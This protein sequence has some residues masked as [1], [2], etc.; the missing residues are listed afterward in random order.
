MCWGGTGLGSSKVFRTLSSCWFL[1]ISL[2]NA[3]LCHLFTAVPWTIRFPTDRRLLRCS[4]GNLAYH[5]DSPCPFKKN[6]SC[7]HV[8]KT[9]VLLDNTNRLQ[10]EWHIRRWHRLRFQ[11]LPKARLSTLFNP[12]PS[13]C[14]FLSTPLAEPAFISRHFC[15]Q[16]LQFPRTFVFQSFH[17]PPPFAANAMM[18]LIRI[19][20]NG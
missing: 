14:H 6:W 5:I 15:S 20:P 17:S 10:N 1:L 12:R 16:T 4:N 13:C 11:W 18:R 7:G 9:L 2:Q 19:D 8:V 3:I